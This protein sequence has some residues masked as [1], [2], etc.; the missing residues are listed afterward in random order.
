MKN[1][2]DEN[3]KWDWTYVPDYLLVEPASLLVTG[4]YIKLQ[5]LNTMSDEK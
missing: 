4:V 2:I 3:A 5:A 1:V